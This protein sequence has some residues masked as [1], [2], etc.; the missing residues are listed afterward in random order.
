[1]R[2]LK[3]SALLIAVIGLAL[4]ISSRDTITQSSSPSY[5]VTDLGTLGGAT[6][7][8][9]SVDKQGPFPVSGAAATASGDLHAFAGG[10]GRGP[11]QDLG[12]LGGRSSEAR[13][14]ALATIVGRAQVASGAYHAFMQVSSSGTVSL[15]DLGTL[16]GSESSANGVTTVSTGQNTFKYLIVG[17]ANTAENTSRAFIYDS[18][19]GTMSDLGATLG[20]PNTFANAINSNQHVAGAAD[21]SDAGPTGVPQHAFLY[22]N[23]VTQDLGSLG[24]DSYANAVNDADV[25]V[26]RS[27]LIDADAGQAFRYQNGAMQSLGTLGGGG[28]EAF[29]VNAAGVIVGTAQTSDGEQHAFVWRDGV[30]TDLNTLIPS[31]TGWVLQAAT[32]LARGPAGNEPIVG[33]GQFHGQTRAFFLTPPLDLSLSVSVH[34]NTEETNRPNPFEAGPMTW[35]ATVWNHGAFTASHVVVTDTVSGPVVIDGASGADSC[36]QNGNQQ[37]TCTLDYVDGVFSGRDIFIGVH[38]TGPGVVTHS[39][40][41]TSADQPDPNTANNTETE[42]NTAVSLSTLILAKTT[43]AG[44]ES[45]LGRTTL[46]SPAPNAGARVTLTSSNPDI[47]SVPAPFDVL[48]GCCDNGTWREFYV[49]TKAVSAPVTVQI[50]ASYGLVTQTVP[51]TI[52]PSST[53][54]PYPGS[55]SPIPGIIQAEDF[56]NGG[57]GLAYHDSDHGNNGGAYR[58]TDVDIEATTDTG[59][60][61]DVGWMTGGEWL[62]YTATIAQSGSYMLTARVAANGAGGTFHVEVA[63]VDK[64]G[65]LTIPNTGGW[66]AWTDISTLVSLTGGTQPVRIVADA[67]GPS[68]VFGNI[69]YVRL[70]SQAGGGGSTPFSGTPSPIP[71]TIQAEN[72]DNG[73]EGVAYHDSDHGNNGGAYRATDV[74]IEA[75]T[76]AGGGYDVGWIAGGEWLKYTASVANA[77]SYNVTFRVASPGGASFHFA[78][79]GVSQAVS[80]PA[81]GGWQNWTSVTVPATLS[82]G[83]QVLTLTFD[84]G[85]MNI[86]YVSFAAGDSGGSGPCAAG[87]AG[88]LSPCSGTP[89]PIPGQINAERFDNGG[90]GV[91]YHD[92]S[93]GNSGGQFRSTDVDIETSSE[94]GY[95]VGW[96]AAGEWLNYTVNVTNAGNYTVQLRVASPG[97]ASFHVGF[98]GP[99]QGQWTIVSV[100]ATGGWQN[101]TTVSVPVTL[102]AGTQQMTILFDTGGM[103]FRT[104]AVGP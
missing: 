83:T 3:S 28:S 65:P 77:G 29:D 56:D 48:R 10:V 97:G 44:G 100:P 74:D 20:G 55:P 21:L 12:T 67:N 99:S 91:A 62:N 96:I 6:S 1:M 57:E 80:V 89:V 50:T 84:T 5:G 52:T 17:Y 18:S 102:G 31:G 75:T 49:T 35:A 92:T 37:V 15:K 8:A 19:T 54:S 39:A 66:Q 32:A 13:A 69:N 87:T 86:G 95:D 85:G 42:T 38:A 70:T 60:G 78:L 45:V 14:N 101:W 40:T 94:G 27:H 59:G 73:G 79:N 81:T 46:T 88:T 61:Y 47:A 7:F 23:G 43:A 64:T 30:M 104:A 98:N 22:V 103:N 26:G 58:A 11:L 63:G 36:V 4:L 72:F 41:I 2:T 68:G 9:L 16:G 24:G 76:D 51:L 33:Y 93:A 25:V 53:T 82:A 90:E 71:G 34:S